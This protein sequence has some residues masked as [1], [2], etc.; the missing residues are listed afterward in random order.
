MAIRSLFAAQRPPTKKQPETSYDREGP[1]GPKGPKH[2]L[3][4][5]G[6]RVSILFAV[7]GCHAFCAVGFFL[8]LSAACLVGLLILLKWDVYS[9]AVW[10]SL[11]WRSCFSSGPVAGLLGPAA[12]FR[13]AIFS[14]GLL[15]CL[16]CVAGVFF[17]LLCSWFFSRP[18]TGLLG[19][20]AAFREVFCFHWVSLWLPLC[21]SVGFFF[22]ACHWPAWSACCFEIVVFCLL[23]VAPVFW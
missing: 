23:S 21:F 22:R 4:A 11:S 19:L 1:R 6:S 16:F 7:C 9:R 12:T 15:V 8:G 3:G 2:E 10:M 5:S 20:P 13:E 17:W 18:V 14:E